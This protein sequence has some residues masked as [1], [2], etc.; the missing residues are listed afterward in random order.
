MSLRGHKNPMITPCKCR[1]FSS[2]NASSSP[3]NS[4]IRL[5]FYS[6][7]AE[8]W[9]EGWAPLTVKHPV[10]LHHHATM[11]PQTSRLQHCLLYPTSSISPS[12]LD[13]F[14]QH[15]NKL[16]FLS[17]LLHP[18]LLQFLCSSLQQCSQ[19]GSLL[20]VSKLSPPSC[21]NYYYYWNII[22]IL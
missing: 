5:P 19:K 21:S 13:H 7:P 10:F 17:S 22:N 16:I 11:D 12:P 14:H 3:D 9:W 4:D 6:L 2:L 20:M 8:S 15:P 1:C 18:P